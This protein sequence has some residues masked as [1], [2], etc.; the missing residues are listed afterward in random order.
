MYSSTASIV[1]L[2]PLKLVMLSWLTGVWSEEYSDVFHLPVYGMG[3]KRSYFVE[4]LCMFVCIS[5]FNMLD[6]FLFFYV[7]L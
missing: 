6:I 7:M 5:E 4:E 3:D 1:V 2:S